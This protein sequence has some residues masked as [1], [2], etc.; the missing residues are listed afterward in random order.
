MEGGREGYMSG[1]SPEILQ[2]VRHLFP[3][4]R[5]KVLLS[6]CLVHAL[7]VLAISIQTGSQNIIKTS[8]CHCNVIAS[9]HKV[10]K[11][12]ANT[13]CAIFVIQMRQISELASSVHLILN[14]STTY[15]EKPII[16]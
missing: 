2:G 9:M 7:C 4:L 16:L 3:K 10:C 13:V 14:I 12:H 1:F 6:Y 15:V 8:N 5:L 11:R